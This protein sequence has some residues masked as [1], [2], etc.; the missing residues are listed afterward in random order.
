ML[1][2]VISPY[3]LKRYFYTEWQTVCL[4]T[5]HKY[6]TNIFSGYVCMHTNT[7]IIGSYQLKAMFQLCTHAIRNNVIS[8]ITWF[9]WIILIMG[10]RSAELMQ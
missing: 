10:L 7:L 5:D 4:S 1:L 9:I 8:L 6:S 3:V 2:D